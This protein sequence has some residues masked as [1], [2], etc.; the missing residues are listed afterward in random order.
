MEINEKIF[1]SKY[2]FDIIFNYIKDKNFKFKLFVHSHLYQKFC[3]LDL[4]L[5]KERFIEQKEIEIEKFFIGN[6]EYLKKIF[7]EKFTK[8]KF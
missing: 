2:I 6:P 8:Y 3:K 5:Y 1:K 4:Y 7:E